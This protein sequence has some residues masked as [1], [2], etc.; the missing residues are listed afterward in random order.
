[1]SSDKLLDAIDLAKQ[2]CLKYQK[3]NP[4]LVDAD[5]IPQI[6]VFMEMKDGRKFYLNI[7]NVEDLKGGKDVDSD[8]KGERDADDR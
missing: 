7:L 8:K 2:L 4:D 3:A 5:A 6:W 1:M